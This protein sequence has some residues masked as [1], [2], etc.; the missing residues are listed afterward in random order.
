MYTSTV[1]SL[2]NKVAA[3]IIEGRPE[4]RGEV[5][6][7]LNAF[8][9]ASVTTAKVEENKPAVTRTRT[10]KISVESSVIE[11]AEYVP[12]RLTIYFNNGSS[13]HY[14]M[15]PR[16]IFNRLL[17]ADSAGAFFS[18]HIRDNFSCK[19]VTGPFEA[20]FHK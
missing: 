17:Q 19:Q 18:E 20:N 14:F 10:G 4:L 1:T 8:G 7:L 11:S 6:S 5:N 13:Y 9:V 3:S 2:I 16:S 15:V 12:G